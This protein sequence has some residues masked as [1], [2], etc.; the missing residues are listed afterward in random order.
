MPRLRNVKPK[1]PNLS[2]NRWVRMWISRRCGLW[3][4]GNCVNNESSR[5][6]PLK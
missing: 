6:T 1:N 4:P 3:G 2:L 5:Y